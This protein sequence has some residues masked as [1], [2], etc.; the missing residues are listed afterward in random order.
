MILTVLF[1]GVIVVSAEVLGGLLLLTRRQWPR[2]VQDYLLALGAGFLLALV[3]SELIPRSIQTI[4]QTAGLVVILGFA[5]IHFFEHTVVGHFHFGEE[6]HSEVMLSRIASVSAFS[7]LF[8]HA[9]FDGFSIAV[10]MRFDFYVGLLIFGAILLHKIPEGLTIASIMIAA[11]YQRRTVLLATLGIGAATM[12]GAMT[13]IFFSTVDPRVT[14]V[15]FAFS[16]GA[17]AYVGASDLIPEINRSE[18]RVI[19]LV[20]FA[21][22]LLFYIT[23]KFLERWIL[24]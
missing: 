23:S 14:G 22:M 4:G 24:G 6:V 17:A 15:A 19:P 3:F 2:R 9:F 5:T 8:I 18:N 21:G 1:F 12:L 20:L 11:S 16:A 10:G 13:I 7:G